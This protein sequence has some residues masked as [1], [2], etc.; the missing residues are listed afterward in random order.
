MRS[1][2][3]L[4]YLCRCEGYHLGVAVE[5]GGD[6]EGFV[7]HVVALVLGEGVVDE[8]VDTLW[9]KWYVV[10]VL[11]EP[12]HPQTAAAAAQLSVVGGDEGERGPSLQ[13]FY[14]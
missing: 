4:L 2:F 8:A 13:Y 5:D 14:D 7:W 1:P 12:S 6:A 3:F 11:D 9:G 10:H